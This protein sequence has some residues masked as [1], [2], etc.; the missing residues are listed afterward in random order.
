MA[1]Y[2]ALVSSMSAM[3]QQ[4]S[5]G[6]SRNANT[7]PR[8]LS[9]TSRIQKASNRNISPQ[10]VQR[11][12]TVPTARRP[13]N[14]GQTPGQ[15]YISGSSSSRA[16]HLTPSATTNDQR[17]Y[18]WQPSTYNQQQPIDAGPSYPIDV[19]QHLYGSSSMH[20]PHN[21]QQPSMWP[22]SST[23]SSFQQPGHPDVLFPQYQS[24][25]TPY[26]SIP[27]HSIAASV[28]MPSIPMHGDT[29]HS[30]RPLQHTL[31]QSHHQD[32]AS[33]SM[34]PYVVP[35]TNAS[36]SNQTFGATEKDKDL[37]GISLYDT[38]PSLTPSTGLLFG[39]STSSRPRGLKL[40]E[41]WT[42]PED[43]VPEIETDDGL[44]TPIAA[45]IQ[46][47]APF[48]EQPYNPYAVPQQM[49]FDGSMPQLQQAYQLPGQS[50][51]FD[52]ESIKMASTWPLNQ[53]QAP[54][55]SWYDVDGWTF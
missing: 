7:P 45:D 43:D 50:F 14:L 55:T 12:K 19:E 5:W 16:R 48:D 37:I 8:N 17:P 34:D 47:F 53:D 30:G 33:T 6:A 32:Y 9:R 27:V 15:V 3:S 42:P 38:G 52:D 41:T 26:G 20:P 29:S 4:F 22:Q 21:L 11:R 49:S 13:Q 40:E 28:M 31:S 46:D 39:T 1:D 24:H 23:W 44:D 51:F 10:N 54:P 25:M 18:S 2:A 35:I 36:P